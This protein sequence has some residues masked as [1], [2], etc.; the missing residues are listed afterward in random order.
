MT[1][2]LFLLFL[3]V[4]NLLMGNIANVF[5]SILGWLFINLIFGKSSYL[6]EL[7]KR[8]RKKPASI[9]ELAKRENL[10]SIRESLE[11]KSPMEIYMLLKRKKPE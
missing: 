2:P 6:Y 3:V 9:D 7:L 11:R 8:E 1:H 4:G 5:L 10:V